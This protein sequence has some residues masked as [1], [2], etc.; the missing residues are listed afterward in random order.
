M[1]LGFQLL[2]ECFEQPRMT[3]RHDKAV[4]AHLVDAL[5]KNTRQTELDELGPDAPPSQDLQWTEGGKEFRTIAKGMVG[6]VELCDVRFSGG[7]GEYPTFDL[8]YRTPVSDW[9]Q[10][11]LHIDESGKEYRGIARVRVAVQSLK[12]GTKVHDLTFDAAWFAE[13][14]ESDWP[15]E[16]ELRI[17]EESRDRPFWGQRYERGSWSR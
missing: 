4:L 5:D 3:G 16:A 12:C 6:V 10:H 2:K 1:F 8:R 15:F 7:D 9:L 11:Y 14:S 17:Y 13:D